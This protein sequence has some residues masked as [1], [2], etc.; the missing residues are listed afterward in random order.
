[1]GTPT[2]DTGA[3]TVGLTSRPIDGMIDDVRVYNRALSQGEVR[4]LYQR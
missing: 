2:S 3:A 4:Q 1:V